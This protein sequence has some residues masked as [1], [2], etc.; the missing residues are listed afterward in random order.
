MLRVESGRF[1]LQRQ[2]GEGGAGVVFQARDR[3]TNSA[4]A[5]K[6]L[7]GENLIA[8]ERF[9]R[10]IA[11]LA[12][13]PHP[14]IVRHI[15][16][17]RTDDGRHYL[18]MEWLDGK[19]VDLHRSGTW[20]VTEVLSLARR[21]VSGLAFAALRGISHR[22]IKPQNLFLVD[23][24]VGSAKILDFGLAQRGAG[25]PERTRGGAVQGTPLYMSP[26]QARGDDALDARTDVFSLGS[27]LYACL[28][29]RAPFLAPQAHAILEQICSEEP[30]PMEERAP[31]VP[32]RLRTLVQAMMRKDREER[33]G[34]RAIAEELGEIAAQHVELAAVTRSHAPD[35]S[36]PAAT[37]RSPTPRALSAQRRGRVS[38]H[39]ITVAVF[40]ARAD[41]LHAEQARALREL[42]TRHGARIELLPDGTHM[43]LPAQ[44]PDTG[45]QALL[46]ARC[47]LGLRHELPGEAAVVICTGRAMLGDA[48]P[49]AELIERAA[50]LLAG[51]P[52]GAVYVDAPSAALLEARFALGGLELE[53][54]RRTLECE[55]SGGEAPRTLLGQ[56]SPF[57]GRKR[58]LRELERTWDGCIRERS[59]RAVLVTAPAGAGKSRL[60][61][62]LLDRLRAFGAPFSLLVGRGEAMRGGTQFG[63]LS[64]ALHG[65]A[66][67]ASSD[68][69]QDNRAALSERVHRLVP[70]TRAPLLAQFLGEL[71]AVH[72]EADASP[73]LQAARLDP[74]LMADRMLESW[75][76][77][78]D[79]L[80]ERGPVLLCIDDLQ[81]ADPA[82]VRYIEAALRSSR[83]R[84]LLVLA[85]ARPE[86]RETF[87][88][89]WAA[90]GLHELQLPGLDAHACARLLERL[91]GA[92][93]EPAL[94]AAL[95]ERADGNPFFLEEL[96]RGLALR[97]RDQGLPE[98]ILAVVQARLDDLGD[99]PKLLIRAASIFGQSFRLDALRALLGDDAPTRA[100]IEEALAQLSEREIIQPA[101]VT[102]ERAYAFRHALLREAAYLLQPDEERALGHCLAAAWLEQQGEAPALLA[103]HYERGGMPERA[104]QCWARAAAQ[105]FE[106]GS[107]DDT[108]RFGARAIACGLPDVALRELSVVLAEARSYVYDDIDAASWAER[109]RSSFPAGTAAWWRATQVAA[110]VQLRSGA[111]GLD[112]LIEEM[113]ACFAP[114]SALPEQAVAIMYTI[115]ESLRVMRDDLAERLL[116][117]LPMQLPAALAGRPEGCLAAARARKA[118]R[119]G[120]LSEALGLGRDALVILRKAGALRD[121][122]DTLNLCGYLLHELGGYADA[123]V[124]LQEAIQLGE[125]I[126]SANDVY[127]AQLNL[128]SSYLCQ[129]RLDDAELALLAAWD[130]FQ[131][132]GLGSFQAEAL[133]HLAQVQRARGELER[134]RQTAERALSLDSLE[135][136]PRALVLATL[137]S[138]DLA[139]G[140]TADALEL[141][142][143]AQQLVSAHGVNEFVG[144]IALT[145]I[146]SLEAAGLRTCDALAQA[147]AWLEAQAANIG[148]ARWRRA[149]LEQVPAH[150]QLLKRQTPGPSGPG[151]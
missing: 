147:L 132:L 54:R 55:R 122:C 91:A 151:V 51:A 84:A 37:N 137:A 22:D 23:D 40:V 92:P 82:S 53:G 42:A 87:P 57:V 93:V 145:H 142:R 60:L 113:I 11:L 89:L 106:V 107:L 15:A 63:V 1:E 143:G 6:L 71:M 33:P 66:E 72:F 65:W 8:Q 47:A 78:L 39:R 104:G 105:A 31:H 4:V 38:D 76:G 86:V 118:Y 111:P 70:E 14:A 131:K 43:V 49:F 115:S 88:Q 67:L 95:L 68:P 101:G 45:G 46:A 44:Q 83:E 56:T 112:G 102:R 35:V 25:R 32:V 119:C 28:C 2:V 48:Q 64:V 114:G 97:P 24:D 69:R 13:L 110:N 108:L 16:H 81:W 85:L 140:R 96:V 3:L 100:S 7:H 9:E 126:G 36:V 61:Q 17:G 74:Q 130:G 129:G 146:E 26:E 149:F 144:Y 12:E 77:F 135:P 94:Q 134:A 116:S 150:A 98:T 59:P 62:A 29:G 120:N 75:L 99:A 52:A 10:E 21:V 138:I 80:G 141:A 41:T 19:T 124:Q 27:V 127:Y 121:V 109:A 148:D 103:D 73:Q 123:E 117:I 50:G 136:A 5:V 128:G 20:T 34:W 79:A 133:G 30:M 125:R 18:V 58:E 90:R 139:A